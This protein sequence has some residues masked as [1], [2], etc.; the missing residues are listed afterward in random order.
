[1]RMVGMLYTADVVS[2]AYMP[3]ASPRL[4]LQNYDAD[5]TVVALMNPVRHMPVFH[6]ADVESFAKTHTS[7]YNELR[8]HPFNFI[9]FVNSEESFT[10]MR[11]VTDALELPAIA[12]I[13]KYCAEPILQ[14]QPNVKRSSLKRSIGALVC[15]VME[16]NGYA[17]TGIQRAVPPVAGRVFHSAE[18][19]QRADWT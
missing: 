8:A 3:S 6:P 13:V 7:Q 10:N 14:T 9:D 2:D 16:A 15:L 19:Y 4:R 1:M 17:K 11:V 12:G 5:N 18:V